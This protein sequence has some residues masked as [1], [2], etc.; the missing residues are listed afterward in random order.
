MAPIG[1]MSKK[2][3]FLFLG[4]VL[5]AGAAWADPFAWNSSYQGGSPSAEDI[6]TDTDEFDNNLS[7]ADINVQR[8]LETLDEMAGGGS[9]I[10]LDLADNGVNE[11]TALSEIA[12]SGDTN[13]I[14][15]E[16]SNDKL[17][18]NLANDWPKAD[19]ADN[20]ANADYG[21][22]TVAAGAWSVEDD[23]H[24]HGDSTV[25]DTITV[26]ASGSVDIAAI[27]AGITRD[28]E[29]D[30]EGEVQTAWGS[31]NILLETE[32]DASSELLALMDDETGSGALTFATDPTL[33]GPNWT[34]L[35]DNT[36]TGSSEGIRLGSTVSLYRQ[37]GAGNDRL[38]ST[39]TGANS[40]ISSF[41]LRN[42]NTGSSAGVGMLLAAGA[43]TAYIGGM[44]AQRTDASSNSRW[45]PRLLS[46]GSLTATD[47]TAALYLQGTASGVEI[48]ADNAL[49]FELPNGSAPTVDAFGELAGDSD[50]WAASRGAP[51][52]YDGTASVA[53]IGALVSDAPSNGQVPTWNTGGTI[54]WET[55]AAG[56]GWT[57]NGTTINADN[58]N[59]NYVIGSTSGTAGTS[60]TA[61][62]VIVD[63]TAPSGA[64]TSAGQIWADSVTTGPDVLLN[65]NGSN[66]STTFTNSGSSSDT[67]TANG[68]A[69]LTTTTVK[70]GS[71]SGLFDGTGDYLSSADS[72]T[73][74]LGSN[75]YIRFWVR[76]GAT[77]DQSFFDQSP[78]GNNYYSFSLE[79]STLN[80]KWADSAIIRGN[81]SVAWSP[82]IN[83]WYY[84]ELS[85]SGADH[86]FFVDGTQ[87]GA[88]Q[89]DS[90]TVANISGTIRIGDDASAGSGIG[91]D[92]NGRLDD[93]QLENSFAGNTANYT[94]PAAETNVTSS[95]ELKVMDSAGNSTTI[96]PHNVKNLPNDRV[97]A[98]FE[99]GHIPVTVHHSNPYLGIEETIDLVELA[100]SV[101]AI[102]GKKLIY[103]RQI[104]V[105]DWEADKKLEWQRKE[106][107][108]LVN[109][110]DPS[111]KAE[112]LSDDE[113]F[114]RAEWVD[115]KIQ[116][117]AEW[118]KRL[119]DN[120]GQLPEN[121]QPPVW[122]REYVKKAK[123]RL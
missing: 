28:T 95:V 39:T 52:F 111:V 3:L 112:T 107:I 121:E 8:A 69:Q 17:L 43:D 51:V 47:S 33:V 74:A 118:Q 20:V 53:L 92:L 100:K 64:A 104:P 31:V 79:G 93:Y 13:S 37:S 66:G 59:N 123:E 78:D 98:Q 101:E 44:A 1:S 16:P 84:V 41:I 65:M 7:A 21:D 114:R 23:S 88:T 89:T 19:L 116:K 60:A 6:K 34:G 14:F 18:I 103:T 99:A 108:K 9:S 29:W 83:T 80:V 77:T 96:S 2:A 90:D 97:T 22:V 73:W 85:R 122:M 26:G 113:L 75:Y 91:G 25:S 46:N 32:I 54:T 38:V 36:G 55:P 10:T 40:L 42:E 4:F 56:S 49:S 68:N 35:M 81:L 87:Q 120:G 63:G 105:R 30:T 11:S 109:A 72:S 24:S 50:L 27:P 58:A 57:D 67:F 48:H 12:T 102:T 70:F 110:S 119:E 71:A 117:E 94:A 76:F 15:S 106:A 62:L 115:A 61:T 45:A 82:S 86:R 5:V